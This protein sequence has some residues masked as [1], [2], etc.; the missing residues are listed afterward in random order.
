M[1]A[2]N[3]KVWN[4]L[5]EPPA[6][7]LKKIGGGRL[8]GMTDINPQWR[9]QAMTEQFGVCGIGWRYDILESWTENGSDGQICVF[10]KI[11]LYIWDD[12]R[13]KWSGAIPG[14]GGSMLVAQEKNGLYTSDE[15]YKMAVTDALSVAMKMLGVAANI[16]MGLSDSKYEKKQPQ[17]SNLPR[18]PDKIT[19]KD[20][21]NIFKIGYQLQ[22][23][24]DTIKDIILWKCGK[25]NVDTRDVK[26]L[27]HFIPHKAFDATRDEYFKSQMEDK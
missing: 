8:K 16:Y 7:A 21:D 4:A 17:I 12:G 27:E 26:M 24:D 2:D 9:Y 5:K 25:E 22:L 23:S 19:K 6:T 20:S 10:A 1:M 13:D 15:A 11:C 14:I 18:K 3:M